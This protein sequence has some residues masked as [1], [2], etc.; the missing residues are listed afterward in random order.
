MRVLDVWYSRLEIDELAAELQSQMKK[1]MSKRLEQ[2]L[3]KARTRDSMTAFSKLTEM[4]DGEPRIV[5]DPPLIER[6]TDL[7]PGH[8]GEQLG[9][10]LHALLRGYRQSLQ[11]DR[12]ILSGRVPNG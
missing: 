12:R 11:T 7:A 2:T 6:V 1:R 10:A 5:S 4:V 9:K 3:A 8:E